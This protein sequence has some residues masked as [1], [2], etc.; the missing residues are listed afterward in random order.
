MEPRFKR[1]RRIEYR[2]DISTELRFKLWFESD[3]YL[4][5]LPSQDDFESDCPETKFQTMTF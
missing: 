5:I 3:W 1:K 2:D 4:V